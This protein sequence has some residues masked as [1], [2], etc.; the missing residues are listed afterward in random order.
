M[1]HTDGG[2][3]KNGLFPVTMFGDRIYHARA[4]CVLP[5]SARCGIPPETEG[6]PVLD[7]VNENAAGVGRR[8]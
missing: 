7:L 5:A 4:V 6:A 3:L 8:R 1:R 2:A